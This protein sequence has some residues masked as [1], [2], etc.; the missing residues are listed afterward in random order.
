LKGAL[1]LSGITSA[2]QLKGADGG[3]QLAAFD[4]G[5]ASGTAALLSQA[6]GILVFVDLNTMTELRR[7]TLQ[8]IPL[9]IAPDAA[10]GAVIVA[11]ADVNAGLTRF[12]KVDV[13]TA[14]VTT[15]NSAS[16]LMAVGLA[17]SADG[18]SIY[19]AM[20]DQLAVLTNQ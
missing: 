8:G 14:T 20:R 19:A 5:Q 6:D 3:W 16:S 17:V 11:F 1:T 10:H 15:L 4:S 18:A 13:A 7:V 12:A 9:R 2:T